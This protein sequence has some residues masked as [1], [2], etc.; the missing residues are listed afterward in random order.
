MEL[1]FSFAAPQTQAGSDDIT[2]IKIWESTDAISFNLVKTDSLNPSDT[3][4]VYDD[5]YVDRFYRISF[6]DDG[7]LESPQSDTMYGSA[8]ISDTTLTS[9]NTINTQLAELLA[10]INAR[11][12]RREMANSVDTYGEMLN[13]LANQV[14][15]LKNNVSSLQRS[16]TSLGQTFSNWVEN[17]PCSE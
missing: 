7:G 2:T 5:G 4:Y 15:T 3:T 11:P 9:I 14:N 16:V 17:P 6:V 1:T 13:Q 12:T 8:L 10:L